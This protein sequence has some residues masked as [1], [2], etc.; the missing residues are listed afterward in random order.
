MRRALALVAI[1]T[2]AVG[3]AAPDPIVVADPWARPLPPGAEVTAIYLTLTARQDDALTGLASP[4][5]GSLELHNSTLTDG[6]M[7]MR[8]VTLPFALDAHTPLAMAP[9]GHHL[10]CMAPGDGFTVGGSVEVTLSFEH[11]GDITLAVPVE[12]R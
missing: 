4:D 2:L 11:A 9:G 1:L 8:Q 7:K 5:C 3:C 12:Q 6:V 10:M